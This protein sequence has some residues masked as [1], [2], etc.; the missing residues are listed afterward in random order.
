[1]TIRNPALV[2]IL[3]KIFNLKPYKVDFRF[4]REILDEDVTLLGFLN[5]VKEDFN[6]QADEFN[7]DLDEA[8]EEAS[9]RTV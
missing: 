3:I 4:E 2:W 1:M 9:S 8:I 6:V 7:K 5:Q